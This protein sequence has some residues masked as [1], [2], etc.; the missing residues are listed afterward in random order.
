MLFSCAAAA[1]C[2]ALLSGSVASSAEPQM[3]LGQRESVL[4]RKVHLES[5]IVTDIPDVPRLCGEI[6]S[7]KALVRVGDAKVF[8]EVEGHGTP[9]VLVNGGP[10]GTHHA[11]HPWFSRM[12][13]IA[14]VIYYDQRGCGQ[15]DY[16]PGPD[17]YSLGQAVADL[18]AIR[19]SLQIDRWVVLGY[20]YGGLLAQS[21]ALRYPEHVSGLVLLGAMPGMSVEMKP[22]RQYDFLSPEEKARIR[23]IP[24]QVSKVAAERAWSEEEKLAVLVFNNHLNG[25]WKRQGFFRPTVED[26]A[27]LVRYEWAHDLRKD[28]RGGIN[29]SLTGVDLGGAFSGCPI[30]TLILEGRWDLTWNT[31]K[32]GLLAANHPGARLVIFENAGHAIFDEDTDRFFSVLTDYI[33]AL[34]RTTPEAVAS[35]K[36]AVE[37]WDRDQKASPAYVI[38][39]AGFGRASME[40]LA[41]GYTRDWCGLV[42]DPSAFLKMGFAL[43]EARNSAEALWLFERMQQAAEKKGLALHRVVALTW[44]GHMLDLLGRRAEAL[45]CYQ[46]VIDASVPGGFEHEQYGLEYDFT[47]YPRARL[48]QPFTRLENAQK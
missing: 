38:R 24:A 25:D 39:T 45:E 9:L 10:G 1:V 44:Q 26:L 13:D 32:P 6:R 34:P 17:G 41:R 47:T 15:S 2:L 36:Q 46:K 37:A 28:F 40:R 21:Y 22:T 43:Y 42:S 4:D 31:D 35:F 8:V 23:E 29:N 27:R 20:S 14:R 33:R 30:P 19:G 48:E 7:K 11:F 16:Q 18:D 5:D 3:P 12:K